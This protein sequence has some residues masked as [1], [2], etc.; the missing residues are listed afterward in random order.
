MQYRRNLKLGQK[1]KLFLIL[2][3]ISMQSLVNSV[4][5]EGHRFEFQSSSGW[6]SLEIQIDQSAHMSVAPAA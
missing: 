5:R 4:H 1:G 6:K 2:Q 3:N